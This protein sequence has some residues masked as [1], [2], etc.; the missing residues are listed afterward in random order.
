MPRASRGLVIK[1]HALDSARYA[2]AIHLVRN[3]FDAI[4][5]H[6]HWKREIA[7]NRNV[8]W[9]AHVADGI[10]AWKRHTEH[11]LD[12]PIAVR[13][14]RYEELH[15]A[16]ADALRQLVLWLERS[17]P[18]AMVDEAVAA[19]GLVDMRQ[20]HPR[21]GARFFRRGEVGA[22]YA[23]FTGEQIHLALQRL[24]PL[25]RKLGYADVIDRFGA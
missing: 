11:W 5:S 4:E 3:P 9:G 22:S 23:S 18:E 12:T 2:R 7:G 17:V 15:A 13:R 8:D 25:L 14:L 24:E 19:S 16:P 6:F 21:L 1:T 10:E 20:L